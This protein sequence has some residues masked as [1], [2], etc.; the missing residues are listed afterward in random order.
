METLSQATSPCSNPSARTAGG[1]KSGY[2]CRVRRRLLTV[3]LAASL[4]VLP[5]AQAR[6]APRIVTLRNDGARVTLHKGERVQLHLSG[7]YRWRGPRVRGRAVSLE[8][9]QYAAD[10]GYLAW[11]VTALARG[12]TVVKA[13]GYGFGTREC[14]SHRCAARVFRVTFVVR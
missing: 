11:S 9:I 2:E 8:R 3:A 13:S 12:K 7:R 6:R 10:P 14:G 4:L 5:A 1:A